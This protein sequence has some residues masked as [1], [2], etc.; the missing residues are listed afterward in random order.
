MI[1]GPRDSLEDSVTVLARTKERGWNIEK[2]HCL[3]RDEYGC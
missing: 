3:L 1:H 2:V